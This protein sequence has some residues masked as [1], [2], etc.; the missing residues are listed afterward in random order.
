VTARGVYRELLDCQWEL[1]GLPSSPVELQRM[2]GATAS[3]WKSW[4]L[5]IARKFPVNDD[6]L[7][8][9]P[10]LETHRARSVG[11][12][13]RNRAGAAK[14]N[15]QRWGSKVISFPAGGGRHEL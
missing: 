14:T 5:L 9:N 1:G 4:A 3:E 6:G 13:D 11:I 8:R 2:I 10:T 7:R 15:N 12:R